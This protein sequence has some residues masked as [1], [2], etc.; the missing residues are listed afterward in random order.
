MIKIDPEELNLE[1]LEDGYYLGEFEICG[2]PFH[3]EF[4]ELKGVEYSNVVNDKYSIRIENWESNNR[5]MFP[6]YV[7]WRN[8]HYFVSIE[9]YAG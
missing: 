6:Q 8:R 4:I 7:K 2:V 5:R 3:V 9:V 1:K